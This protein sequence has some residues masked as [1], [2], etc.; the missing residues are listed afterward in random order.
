MS[1]EHEFED[2]EVIIKRNKNG[3]ISLFVNSDND[4]E[5]D[6]LQLNDKEVLIIIEG[7]LSIINSPNKDKELM[8]NAIKKASE[9][10]AKNSYLG[11]NYFCRNWKD[12]AIP[13]DFDK[14]M[15]IINEL[16]K[17]GLIEIY[18]NTTDEVK[19]IRIL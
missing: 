18:E 1:F 2:G 16:E 10:F 8:L 19:S 13:R 15:R 5:N 7:Y 17:N 14:R 12:E 11:L 6:I 3:K 9:K 4:E